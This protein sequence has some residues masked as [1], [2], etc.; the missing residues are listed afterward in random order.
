MVKKNC[1][2]LTQSAGEPVLDFGCTVY[3]ISLICFTF[4]GN[5]FQ[6]PML[7]IIFKH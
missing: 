4:F 1:I 7:Y 5:D 6:A 2:I 3:I